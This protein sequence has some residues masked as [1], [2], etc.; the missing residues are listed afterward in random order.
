[1]TGGHNHSHAPETATGRHRQRLVIVVT[2]TASI[3]VAQ[4]TQRSAEGRPAPTGGESDLDGEFEQDVAMRI[5]ELLGRLAAGGGE[6]RV[7]GG[8][9]E[10]GGGRRP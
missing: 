5:V 9:D 4:V 10:D 7:E 2:I 8:L 3:F 6:V 1:M